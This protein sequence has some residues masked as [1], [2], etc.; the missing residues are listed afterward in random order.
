MSDI[1]INKFVQY[2]K[3]Q[4]GSSDIELR[5]KIKQEQKEYKNEYN[6]IY[7]KKNVSCD[8][9]QKQLKRGSLRIHKKYAC[10]NRYDD[11][12]DTNGILV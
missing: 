8:L 6:K 9:C 3:S 10:K 12:D 1:D 5:E 7:S 2:I 4:P 11:T